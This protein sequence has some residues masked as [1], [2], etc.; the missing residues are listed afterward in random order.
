MKKLNLGCGYD[1]REGWVNLD[2]AQIEGVDV[3]HDLNQLPLPFSENEF[4]YVLCSDILEHMHDYPRLLGEV[5]RVLKS[6]GTVE[7]R[8][9]HY[10]YSRAYADPTHVRHFSIET[11]DFFV[12]T[13]G[14]PYYFDFS[15]STLSE[16]RLTFLKG[17]VKPLI[18][19]LVNINRATLLF[20]EQSFLSGLFPAEN[21]VAKLVK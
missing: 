12:E 3:I 2:I 7:I 9:P 15:F 11:L 14:R 21:I 20:Y 13:T 1:T 10:T 5:H 4:D 17:L 18:A 19:P 8:V 16:I 6:G